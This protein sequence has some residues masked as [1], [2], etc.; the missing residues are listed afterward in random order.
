MDASHDKTTLLT[1][2]YFDR[3][4]GIENIHSK[5]E[6]EMIILLSLLASIL[7]MFLG[8]CLYRFFPY[9]S[10]IDVQWGLNILL[11]GSINLSVMPS[12]TLKALSFC[13]LL[14]W[15]GR[16]SIFLFFS[17]VLKK[18]QDK[19]YVK[20]SEQWDNQE[21]GFLKQYAIQAVLAW[22]IALPFFAVSFQPNVD[23]V[24]ILAFAMIVI[25]LLGETVA[26]CQL[27]RHKKLVKG[28]CRHGL[29]RYSRHPNYFFECLVWFGFSCLGANL[30]SGFV[31]FLSIICLYSIM[32]RVSIPLTES[33]LLSSKGE[34]YAQYA[35]ETPV[36]W[37]WK[38]KA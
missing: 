12:G 17:R 19:R 24:T 13:A 16:L 35:K 10:L 1:A 14:V 31:S 33:L 23:S 2:S 4:W 30:A 22:I 6:I 11:I 3:A 8:W 18:V 34:A 27:E 28:V 5:G 37:L 36:F 32:R 15:A 21:Q 29:W 20:M 25:G 7:F 38:P 26:D 9:F